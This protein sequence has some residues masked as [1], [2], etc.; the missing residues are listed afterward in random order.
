MDFKPIDLSHL[1]PVR[2]AAGRERTR[3]SDFSFINLWAW[4]AEYKYN[5]CFERGAMLVRF[6]DNADGY[7]YSFPLGCENDALARDII[8]SAGAKRFAGLNPRQLEAIETM[9]PGR[10]TSE[11]QTDL[12]DY[13]YTLDKLADLSGKKLHNKRTHVRRFEESYPN[14]T[15]ELVTRDNIG[16]CILAVGLWLYGKDDAAFDTI[17]GES[18][19]FEQTVLKYCELD[20]LGGLL[21]VDGNIAA[22]S[23]GELLSEDTFVTHFEKAVPD[24]PGAYQVIN[25]DFAVLVK[26]TYPQVKYVNREDDMGLPGLRQAKRSYYPEIL[27]EKWR[28]SLD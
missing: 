24:M 5:V 10:V 15:F 22:F 2:E 26:N 23:I 20:L 4:R 17:P 28:A 6:P 1:L 18:Q 11:P 21:R 27:E 13:I 25:R 7:I 14:Y 9:Y 3:N 19:A 16:E 8:E 12:F